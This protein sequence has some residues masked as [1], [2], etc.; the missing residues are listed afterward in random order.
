VA[1]PTKRPVVRPPGETE[2]ARSA[3]LD[4]AH[5]GDIR[6]ALGT[7]RVDDYA[8]RRTWRQRALTLLAIIGPRMISRIRPK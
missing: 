4:E 6:G 5:L 8:V 3:V 1:E 7:I 2:T